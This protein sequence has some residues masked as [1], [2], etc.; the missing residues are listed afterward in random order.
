MPSVDLNCD[1]G[2][3]FGA[4]RLGADAEV[5][6]HVTSANIACGF[7][8]GD[9]ATMRKTVDLAAERGVAIGAHPGLPD[10]G[11]F[12]RRVIEVT[13]DEAYEM[14]VYQVGALAAFTAARG[15]RLAHVKPH[16]ALYNMAATRA[17][18]ADAIARAVRD[19]D[20]ALT[21]FG[22]AGSSLVAAARAA[23]IVAVEEVFAD[24]RYAASGTLVSRGERGAVIDDTAVAVRQAVR[25]VREGMVTAVDG[26]EVRVHADTICI[27]GDTAG[28]AAHA[29]ALRAALSDAGIDVAAPRRATA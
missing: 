8:A 29:R 28:A 15:A 26:S 5:L 4:W 13:P 16:G 22:L 17:P 6:S 20:P 25:M 3:S 1:I 19:V 27:H 9:P 14:V 24:R 11:G 10:L 18:L 7:H 21:L 12:G 2:E 23:G